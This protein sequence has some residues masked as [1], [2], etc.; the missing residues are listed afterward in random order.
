[1]KTT[2]NTSKPTR[3]TSLSFKRTYRAF[4]LLSLCLVGFAGTYSWVSWQ[5][6]KADELRHAEQ[7]AEL[8]EKSLNAYFSQIEFALRLT[9]QDLLDER[10]RLDP[11]AAQSRLIG[12]VKANP[13]LVSAN[14]ISLDGF[15]ILS[16]NPE[17]RLPA[18]VPN[19][20]SLNHYIGELSKGQSLGIGLPFI[21]PFVKEW[22]IPLRYAVRDAV[23]NL[24]YV[25]TATMPLSRPQSF[26]K[27]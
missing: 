27:T 14:I 13:N 7:L 16:S 26:C 2:L 10:G 8:G 23:G 4:A 3:N 15:I 22:L 12:L 6:N 11:I 19:I 18:P 9:G 1:M 21:G 20:A 24:R 25:L 5:S 17:A